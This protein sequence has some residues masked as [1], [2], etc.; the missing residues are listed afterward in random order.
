[1]ITRFFLRHPSRIRYNGPNLFL[2]FSTLT[3]S[4]KFFIPNADKT[5]L[6]TVYRDEA[7]L[8]LQKYMHQRK[9][10]LDPNSAFTSIPH[11]NSDSLIFENT[12]EPSQTWE[13]ITTNNRTLPPCA[14]SIIEYHDMGN[15]SNSLAIVV[16]ELQSKFN[17][18]HNKLI[19]LTLENE[20][21][22]VYPQDINFVA[23]QVFD[24]EWIESLGILYHRF[25]EEYEPRL[26]LV[27]ILRQFITTTKEMQ[28]EVQKELI[29]VYATIASSD[30]ANSTS[31]LAVANYMDYDW[32]SYF[33][34]SAFLMA[35][36]LEMCHDVT[37]WVVLL[38][39][40][41]RTTNL[42]STRC[43]NDIPPETVYFANL[44]NNHDAILDFLSYDEPKLEELKVYLEKLIELPKSYD[45][46]IVELNIWLGKPF[47]HAFKTLTF[48]LVHPHIRLTSLIGKLI[49]AQSPQPARLLDIENLLVQIGLFNNPKN[50]LTDPVL[51]SNLL[52]KPSLDQLMVASPKELKPSQLELISA[53]TLSSGQLNDKFRHLRKSKRYFLDHV[54]YMLPSDKKFSSIGIS[55]EKIN[56]RK[57]LINIHVPDV[58]ARVAP[59]SP[60][61]EEVSKHSFSLKSLKNLMGKELIELLA[62]NVRDEL[63]L[64]L[65]AK[66]TNS[67]FFSVGD[68]KDN[69]ESD[70]TRTCMTVTYEYNTFALSP[71]KELEKGVSVTFDRIL[72]RQ[73][74][75]LSWDLLDDAISGRLETGILNAFK[76]F[77]RRQPAEEN[78]SRVTL[79]E[80]DI[81][82]LGFIFNVM[83]THFNTR[84][85]RCAS[86]PHPAIFQRSISRSLS[87]KTK[88][89]EELI[90]TDLAFLSVDAALKLGLAMFFTGEIKTFLDS[91]VASFCHRES[92][93]VLARGD[94]LLD[95]DEETPSYKGLESDEV[96][97]SHDNK[98]L[99]NYY[100]NSYYQA[101]MAKDRNGFVS[102]PALII[103]NNYLGKPTLGLIGSTYLLTKGL[104]R[105]RV[106]VSDAMSNVEAYLNQL[107]ILSYINLQKIASR[108][109]LHMV[110]QTLHYKALGYP[111]HGPLSENFMSDQVIKLQDAKLGCE[112]FSERYNRYWK[113]K[114]LEQ[115]IKAED[116]DSDSF[117]F[118]CVLTSIGHEIDLNSKLA[119]CWCTNLALEVDLLLHPY[120]D[121]SIGS[122]VTADKVMYL[123]AIEGTCVLR[124][125]GDY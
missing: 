32:Q 105:G 30:N 49:S 91:L 125:K 4:R 33:H 62:K 55:L 108:N 43:S 1:M 115:Q 71:L 38:C 67:E 65:N 82:N 25:A 63:L 72:P 104:P 122:S 14:G 84:A 109:Y 47:L 53:R 74:K 102:L 6:D 60:L 44:L 36:H 114:F 24:T 15:D 118:S 21:S 9:Q 48:A 116:D 18:N 76:L 26:Q 124:C 64:K 123:N 40:P 34:Q 61:F 2:C 83:K 37:R 3:R 85:I 56:A 66:A 28:T 17:E 110:A 57:F 45:D 78:E 29:K 73:V 31:I 101:I 52:G 16:R 113:L 11:K 35:I 54:I 99:P 22:R 39:I 92:I 7:Q 80:S 13:E 12:F 50:P 120:N 59:A 97:V 121:L 10:F 5:V 8:K 112:F 46:L 87:Y 89:K 98:L 106:E 23:Y 81:L 69:S 70:E 27:D 107:Q 79:D 100:C 68:F 19:V 20:L 119:R 75:V 58:A 77:N 41:K 90:Q 88:D 96:F 111:V 95:P 103:G 93:P 42:I 51:S 86:E 94:D 117:T